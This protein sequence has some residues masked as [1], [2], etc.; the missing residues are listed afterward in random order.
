M[1]LSLDGKLSMI[2]LIKV[3]STHISE[4]HTDVFARFLPVLPVLPHDHGDN[5]FNIFYRKLLGLRN[6]KLVKIQERRLPDDDLDK[7]YDK[8]NMS[9][10]CIDFTVRNLDNNSIK[11]INFNTFYKV[12]HNDPYDEKDLRTEVIV[13]L[14]FMILF[15][16]E[17]G[18]NLT[19]SIPKPLT[20]LF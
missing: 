12:P 15:Y 9:S 17:N 16:D 5:D 7:P 13:H 2:L 11:R 6:K 18:V 3:R 20:Y 8:L 10:T 14:E 19:K 1:E 4:E